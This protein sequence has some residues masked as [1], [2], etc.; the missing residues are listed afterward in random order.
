MLKVWD[1]LTSE[2]GSISERPLNCE[3]GRTL[4]RLKSVSSSP[5][6]PVALAIRLVSGAQGNHNLGD[7]KLAH[8]DNPRKVL[9]GVF[10]S[11]P[12]ARQSLTR[13]AV[14]LEVTG[15]EQ[16]I[17]GQSYPISSPKSHFRLLFQIMRSI[18]PG[19]TTSLGDKQM[20]RGILQRKQF[21]KDCIH[22]LVPLFTKAKVAYQAF[23]IPILTCIVCSC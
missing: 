16:P 13:V 1:S 17:L 12:T 2:R 23:L 8:E 21:C 11:E 10:F 20:T 15:V 4:R 5:S 9:P 7:N 3:S 19:T 18:A 14:A 22:F 6:S